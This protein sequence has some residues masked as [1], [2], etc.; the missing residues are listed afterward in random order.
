MGGIIRAGTSDTD[1]FDIR[2]DDKCGDSST[3]SFPFYVKNKM[4]GPIYV[5]LHFKD[6]FVQHRNSIKSV[7][8]NQLSGEIV[9][10]DAAS[11]ACIAAVR[12]EDTLR[13]YSITGKRLDPKAVANPCGIL[14]SLFPKGIT[15]THIDDF[16]LSKR[17]INNATQ[18]ESYENV[19]IKIEGISWAGYKE[20]KFKMLNN[21][22]DQWVNVTNERFIEWMRAPLRSSFYKLWG[23]I[24]QNLE[25][26][27]YRFD[28]AN[29]KQNLNKRRNL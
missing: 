14:A 29:G 16:I 4:E 26:G 13:D 17:V 11:T 23:R 21:G 15:R 18:V 12:N 2:F 25:K 24:D 20:K 9:G 27:L 1:S 28:I 6:F 19:P 5:Y 10:Y 22:A 8:Q 7:S 3:C